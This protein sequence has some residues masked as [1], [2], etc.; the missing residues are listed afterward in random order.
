MAAAKRKRHGQLDPGGDGYQH[1]DADDPEAPPKDAAPANRPKNGPQP[2][3]P[4]WSLTAGV[5]DR[6]RQ[7]AEGKELPVPVPKRRR[8]TQHE[9]TRRLFAYSYTIN[10]RSCWITTPLTALSAKPSRGEKNLPSSAVA[11]ANTLL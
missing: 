4:V 11:V 2:A 1:S 10:L 3:Q 8:T 6:I 9:P 7:R 5:V